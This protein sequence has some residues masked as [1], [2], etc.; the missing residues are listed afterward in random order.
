MTVPEANK[1]MLITTHDIPAMPAPIPLYG[2][3]SEG[4]SKILYNPNPINV[5]PIPAVIAAEIC[6][7]FPILILFSARILI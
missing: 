4:V 5:P 6:S 7:V 3:N 2:K 1:G